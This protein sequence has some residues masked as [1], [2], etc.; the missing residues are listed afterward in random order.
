M[1]QG[2]NPY[3]VSVT[4]RPDEAV[5]AAALDAARYMAM[6]VVGVTQWILAGRETVVE[7]MVPLGF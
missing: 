2:G 6:R 4:A 3:G 5:S 7:E 1:R